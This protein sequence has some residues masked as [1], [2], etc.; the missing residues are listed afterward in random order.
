L[1]GTLAWPLVFLVLRAI[2]VLT[3]IS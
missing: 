3:R 2:R 1:T